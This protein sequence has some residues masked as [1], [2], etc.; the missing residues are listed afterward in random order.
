[1]R[2][3]NC[4]LK[5]AAF[6]SSRT[7]R[8]NKPVQQL[9]TEVKL[10]LLTVCCERTI[11]N[12][13]GFLIHVFVR[14]KKLQGKAFPAVEGTHNN[15]TKVRSVIRVRVCVCVCLPVPSHLKPRRELRCGSLSCTCRKD[16][17]CWVTGRSSIHTHR[18]THTDTYV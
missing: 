13:S 10:F 11:H 2:V 1:M 16:S 5:K 6:P 9:Q 12:L 7:P 17:Y 3:N 14:P 4:F 18:H 8:M 15:L